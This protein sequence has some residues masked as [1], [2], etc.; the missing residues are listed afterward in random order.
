MT[1]V[2]KPRKPERGTTKAKRHL[3]LVAQ[4]SCVICGWTPV[5]CHHVIMGRFAQRKSSDFS[6]IPLCHWHHNMVHSN[7][8]GW[9][10]AYGADTD[11]LPRVAE[12][13]AELA[14]RSI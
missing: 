5:V 7:P 12:M 1:P 2:P 14:G 10:A 11:Y 9:K 3:A 4:L 6:T 8:A 13:I